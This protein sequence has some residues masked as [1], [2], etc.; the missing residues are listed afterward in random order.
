MDILIVFITSFLA[1]VLQGMWTPEELNIWARDNCIPLFILSLIL[2]FLGF[3][4]AR[5]LK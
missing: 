5:L 2:I 1:G 4:L 3:S